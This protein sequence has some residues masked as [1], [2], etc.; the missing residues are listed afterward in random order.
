MADS[1]Y[2]INAME[3]GS[4]ITKLFNQLCGILKLMLI[5]VFELETNQNEKND[6]KQN[7]KKFSK[8]VEKEDFR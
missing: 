1:C 3:F 6:S 4:C 5:M 2:A 7:L 8:I